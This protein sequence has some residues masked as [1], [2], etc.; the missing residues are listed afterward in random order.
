M[1][2]RSSSFSFFF[3]PLRAV[4][5]AHNSIIGRLA[6]KLDSLRKLCRPTNSGLSRLSFVS[7]SHLRKKRKPRGP[8]PGAGL[9]K[10]L[11]ANRYF[12]TGAVVASFLTLV[13]WLT[14]LVCFLVF[15]AGFV[16]VVAVLP[17]G[18]LV[19]LAGRGGADQGEGAG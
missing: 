8:K 19:W 12:A 15:T 3:S 4:L 9:W 5:P 7:L 6:S 14:F 11:L 16:S 13:L 18:G 10:S 2:L 1:R 17:A